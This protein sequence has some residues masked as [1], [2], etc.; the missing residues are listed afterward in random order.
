[1]ENKTNMTPVL[2]ELIFWPESDNK[3]G[4]E[5]KYR[6]S[7]GRERLWRTKRKQGRSHCE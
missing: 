6:D 2:M 7:R 3:Q 5:V 4:T 1:M